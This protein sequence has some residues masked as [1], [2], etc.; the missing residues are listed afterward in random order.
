MNDFW[1]IL[2]IVSGIL[3]F[4][5]IIF[6]IVAQVR[7]NSAFNNYNKILSESNLTAAEIAE[8]LL[9]ASGCDV[10]VEK[11]K[12]HLTDNFNP[13]TKTVNLSENVYSS[14]SIASIGIAAHEV[15]HAI[16]Y[17]NGYAPIKFRNVLI[18]I[19][20]I[21]NI[22]LW[23]LIIIGVL[24]SIFMASS[25]LGA[26]IIIGIVVFYGLAFLLSLI[27]LPIEY[28]AS[29]RAY[30][31][32]SSTEILN[33]GEAQGAR[34][35]LNAAALTYVAGMLVSMVYFLRMLSYLLVFVK[36]D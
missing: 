14:T 27:T 6:A 13:K 23:P 30:A 11:I 25:Y 35:V 17:K 26:G 10:K 32:L 15:G 16:Q 7:V 22:L 34:T 1:V 3:I 8:R 12:G 2:Y 36:R 24:F 18:P 21:G 19:L 5:T 4:P 9:K 29:N 33:A 31:M 20:N 28:D